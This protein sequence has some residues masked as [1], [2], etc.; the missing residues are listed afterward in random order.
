M[1]RKSGD[2]FKFDDKW[3]RGVPAAKTLFNP[4]TGE[5]L[6]KVRDEYWDLARAALRPGR[7]RE[8]R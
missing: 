8:G 7:D 5:P 6:A 3:L 4:E 1:A 2:R